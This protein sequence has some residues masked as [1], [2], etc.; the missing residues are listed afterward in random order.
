MKYFAKLLKKLFFHDYH[1]ILINIMHIILLAIKI[2][3]YFIDNSA[4]VE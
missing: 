3:F 4:I 2:L 1:D